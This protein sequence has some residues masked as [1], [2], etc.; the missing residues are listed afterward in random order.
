MGLQYFKLISSCFKG[1]QELMLIL[2]IVEVAAQSV[3]EISVIKQFIFF[4]QGLPCCLPVWTQ[5][6]CT[7]FPVQGY[8]F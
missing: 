6:T 2:F 8:E 1:H 7:R 3:T 5:V 4:P